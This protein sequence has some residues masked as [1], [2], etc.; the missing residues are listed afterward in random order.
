MVHFRERE[1][2]RSE[3]ECWNGR[4]KA[5]GKRETQANMEGLANGEPTTRKW[6]ARGGC[7][8]QRDGKNVLQKI[9]IEKNLSFEETPKKKVEIKR[10]YLLHL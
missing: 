8:G 1:R 9:S 5:E 2:E 7:K 3:R 6:F 10:L 4:W